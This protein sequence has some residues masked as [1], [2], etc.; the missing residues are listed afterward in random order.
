MNIRIYSLIMKK[1]NE[2]PN[3]FDNHKKVERIS[4]FI[5]LINL[6]RILTNMNIFGNN[7]SN[8]FMFVSIRYKFMRQ[9]NSDIRST[10]L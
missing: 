1:P 6:D 3:K 4:E 9:I 10:F 5:R 7:Y 2:Y 8:V